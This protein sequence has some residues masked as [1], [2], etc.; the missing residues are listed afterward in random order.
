[1]KKHL[2]ILLLAVALVN[3]VNAQDSTGNKQY[4][5]ITAI[6]SIFAASN[7]SS[8]IITSPD[9]TQT[10]E[11]LDNIYNMMGVVKVKGIKANELWI[12]QTLKKYT[13]KG[14]KLEQ[15]IPFS[16]YVGKDVNGALMT[17]YLLSK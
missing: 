9:G 8:L 4:M 17:R 11:E 14:W 1:M 2:L 5:Q 16:I 15:T 7:K 10:E 12:V 13:D 6:E 3:F